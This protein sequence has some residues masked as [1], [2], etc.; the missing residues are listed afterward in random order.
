MPLTWRQKNTVPLLIEA[1]RGARLLVVGSHRRT[2]P[3]SIGAGYVDQGLL[4]HS[5]T[6]VAVV[7]VI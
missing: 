3:L 5:L 7:P 1:S 2:S 6:P 4:C